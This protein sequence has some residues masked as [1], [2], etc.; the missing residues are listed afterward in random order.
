MLYFNRSGETFSYS[1]VPILWP[2]FSCAR[3]K[4][5]TIT[6]LNMAARSGPFARL[7]FKPRQVPKGVYIWATHDRQQ[8]IHQRF[9]VWRVRLP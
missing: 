9:S 8:D 7:D 3:N 5:G 6:V 2:P 1:L 4:K